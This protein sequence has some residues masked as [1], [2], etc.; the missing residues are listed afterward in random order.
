MQVGWRLMFKVNREAQALRCL[1]RAVSVVP[2]ECTHPPKGYWKTPELWE[3][4]LRSDFEGSSA[5]A[6]IELL[7][8]ADALG[9]GWQITGPCIDRGLV[10]HLNGV[11]NA[12]G[13]GRPRV[14]GLQWAWFTVGEFPDAQAGENGG[15][16]TELEG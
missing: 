15:D 12:E 13:S 7:Q 14:V 4:S 1:E 16:F 3:T 8:V 9:H 2:G 6:V 5:T 10:S 11:F